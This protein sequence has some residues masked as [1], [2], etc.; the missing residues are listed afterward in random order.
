[1]S[2]D[3]VLT[4]G[5]YR[6]RSF[7]HAIEPG[8][9]LTLLNTGEFGKVELRTQTVMRFPKPSG[10]AQFAAHGPGGAPKGHSAPPPAPMANGWQ[11]YGWWDSGDKSIGYF[12][13]DWVVPA[14]PATSSG[15]TVFLFNG[16]QNTGA[17]YGILQ[18]VLQWGPSAHPGGGAFWAVASWY[19]SSNG[20]AFYSSLVKVKAGDKLQGI[21][22]ETG[23]ASGKYDYSCTFH[24]IGNTTLPIANIAPLHWA[25]ET[26]ECY[27]LTKCSDMPAGQ[28][29][30]TA[31]EIRIGN[32]HP[33]LNW[34]AVD[35][36][37]DCH[38]HT[39]VVSNANPN[40]EV[41]IH[42]S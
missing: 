27:N 23:S 11:T 38:Q 5:G 39:T 25:N 34:T 16:I 24:G 6:P 33:N 1:M 17:N 28:T 2:D 14:A 29:N 8:Y 3:L 26:L 13:T 15:Q 9:G 19:V 7:V 31:I 40:G 20:Q 10:H 30:M 4:P 35:A 22:T 41:D 12:T 36:I 18:P 32:A 21:M 37:T 42:Y